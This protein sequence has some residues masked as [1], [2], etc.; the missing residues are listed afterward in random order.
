MNA[1]AVGGHQRVEQF[2]EGDVRVARGN[3]KS[4]G[5]VTRFGVVFLTEP[6]C[7]CLFGGLAGALSMN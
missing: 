1:E 5:K 4:S 7:F 3:A 6:V 2:E